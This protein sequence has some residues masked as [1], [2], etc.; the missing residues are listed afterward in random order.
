MAEPQPLQFAA[1]AYQAL[2]LPLDAQVCINHYVEKSP[3]DA[4]TQVPI[5][6]CPGVQGGI[7]LGTGPIQGL[8]VFKGALLVVSG[9]ALYSVPAAG[10]ATLIGQM[11]VAR[12]PSIIDNGTQVCFVDGQTGWIYQPG[13]VNFETSEDA[14]SGATVLDFV[15]TGTMADG[16][17]L[18]I[19]LD[20]GSAFATT[21]SSIT[22]GTTV[23]LGGPL[24]SSAAAGSIVVDGNVLLA[25]ITSPSF[26][27][28]NTVCYFDDYFVFDKKG[29]NQYFLSALNDGTQYSGLDYASAETNPGVMLA[30]VQL[31]EIL[32]L[33]TTQAIESWYDA[34]NLTFPFQRFDGGTIQRGLASSTAFAK[35][36]NTLFWLGEDLVF[37]RLGGFTPQR[38]STHALEQA[39]QKYSTVA[40]AF[41]MNVTWNGHKWVVL[42]FPTGGQ[43]FVW[44][45]SSGLWHQ[46]VSWNG[47]NQDIGGWRVNAIA[48]FNGQIVVGDLLSGQIGYFS[49]SVYTEWGNTIPGVITSPPQHRGRA[50]VFYPVFELDIESGVGLP[51]GQGSNPQIMLDWSDDGGRTY[52]QK[53]VWRSMGA[54]GEYQT[55]LRWNR[56]GVARQRI[57]RLTCTDPVP[58]RYIGTYQLART[59]LT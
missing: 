6:G 26:S 59:G 50:R 51:T 7:T 41:C 24:P 35:E 14:A 34:G 55:R 19:Q 11:S 46:R 1:Q 4:K 39:W 5:F 23:N 3:P 32:N 57:W 47:K 16:D 17:P 56:C 9:Q 45:I 20:D 58:R 21:I 12:R 22:G 43:T 28:A 40:D 30:V 54:Q 31:H 42:S 10:S 13:G 36:D 49:D 48:A 18:S 8:Y 2:S 33:M 29:T 27:P 52:S 25:Q 15:S 44:D 53:Q 38:I 37:Y